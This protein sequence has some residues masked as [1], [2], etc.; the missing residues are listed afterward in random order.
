[1]NKFL[2][3]FLLMVFLSGAGSSE[4]FVVRDGKII[5]N[6]TGLDKEQCGLLRDLI[7]HKGNNLDI[8][9]NNL[10][11]DHFIPLVIL[12]SVIILTALFCLTR[13]ISRPKIKKETL[14]SEKKFMFFLFL[15]IHDESGSLMSEI[16]N[17]IVAFNQQPVLLPN[18]ILFMTL[19]AKNSG[20]HAALIGA[21]I[22]NALLK[23]GIKMCGLLHGETITAEGDYCTGGFLNLPGCALLINECAENE[24]FITQSALADIRSDLAVE[25]AMAEEYHGMIG[26]Q[27][28]FRVIL[29]VA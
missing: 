29:F 11:R 16:Q 12:A 28:V 7:K 3:F 23:Q 4:H 13:R 14:P 6:R 25:K 8:R 20:E 5:I 26:H 19:I 1:M 9:R 2:S 15:K 10:F 27:T 18:R 24:L 17:S 21:D 22:Y